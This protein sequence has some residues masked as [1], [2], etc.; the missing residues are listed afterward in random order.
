MNIQV[1]CPYQKCVFNCPM[2]IAKGHKHKYQ[3][4]DITHMSEYYD[5]LKE[6]IEIE[7]ECDVILTGEC[8]PSQNMR[9]VKKTAEF[10][11]HKCYFKGKVELQTRN[12][13]INVSDLSY[14]DVL[15]Y[16]IVSL[17]DYI[18]S[19][20]FPKLSI[21]SSLGLGKNRLVIL[22]TKEFEILNKDT[23]DPM[24]YDQVTFKTL[25]YGEDDSV[26]KWI[27]ENKMSEDGLER[28]KEIIEKY[29][30][31]KE[32]SVRL[33]TSCQDAKGR[34][35]IYRSDGKTY[36]NWNAKTDRIKKLNGVFNLND[37]DNVN[38]INNVK[39]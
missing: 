32:C 3:F 27:D 17:R 8:D 37:V 20:S 31:S 25:Q 36:T 12:Y 26:N 15:S 35:Y 34:Y 33:D 11:K 23:F 2:C 28:I 22:L 4:P 38:V 13:S 14:I 1:C 39:E 19:Y 6:L 30:G 18:R 16:S 10:L 24:G 29:S 9:W 5:K 21:S 7:H